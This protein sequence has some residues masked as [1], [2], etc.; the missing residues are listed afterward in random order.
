MLA[1]SDTGLGMDAATRARVF[2]PFFTTKEQG[3]GTGPRPRD[4][5]RHRE[6]ERR[7]HLGLQRAR[8]RHDVQGLP[9]AV[10]ADDRRAG[11][12]ASDAAETRRARG[13]RRCC[14]SRTRT[15]SARSRARCCAGSGYVVLEA[16][17]G[18]R[19]ARASPSGTPAP[20]HL[21]VTDVVMPHMSGRELAERLV[22][23][24]GRTMKVLFMSGYTD[25]AVMHRELM[26]GSAFLQKPFTPDAF[27]R[28]VRGV[29]DTRRG[30]Q[31]NLRLRQRHCSCTSSAVPHVRL[32]GSA[33]PAVPTSERPCTSQ[34]VRRRRAISAAIRRTFA[35][36]RPASQR[37]G[38]RR[39][40][41]RR[42]SRCARED[43]GYFSG[44]SPHRAG[45]SVSVSAGRRRAAVSR[46]GVAI[47]ARWSARP[48]GDRRLRPLPLDR[49]G[50]GAARAMQ[51]QVIYEMHVGTFTREGTWAAARARAAELAALGITLI[52]VM[53][54]A[55][56]PGRFG[57]GYDGVDLFA[58]D[59]SLRHA[60][61]I[62]AR[63]V[64]AAHALGLGVILDVVYNHFGPDGNYLRA[65]SPDYFTDRYEN[66]WGEAI[67]F[68]GADAARC[69]S[70][71][72][73]T[74][75]TG[76]TSSTSTACA[77]TR[78]SRSSTP[79][80]RTS[81]PRSAARAREAARRAHDLLVAENE[82]QD[83]RLVRP[84]DDGGYGLDA[85][86]NDDFH[87][88][89]DGRRSPAATRRTTP[90]TAARRRSSSRRRSTAFCIRGS[91]TRGRSSAA[92]RRRSDL[93]PR[94]A[95]S[96]HR[97]T[98]I[99]SRTRRAGCARIS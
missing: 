17:H 40:A 20:I 23:R 92:A 95:S 70:S 94:S 83:T 90:T 9:A 46:S 28:K 42:D 53:P 58:P 86:W 77:S 88:T 98:T 5:L 75:R 69:A 84:V 30:A 76:S 99:R 65:F 39:A 47:S 61:T 8:Q 37:R 15:P 60:R 11:D 34:A 6:A 25:H 96:V 66:E 36:G 68:D 21:M 56:F 18:A 71:S 80:R 64:D 35:S 73:R 48:L 41:T 49:R 89:R 67:N 27:A 79:R 12:A 50:V 4:R 38:R 33:R 31:L 81:S 93:A 45:R 59:A 78:R 91:A 24:R 10:D 26:P 2:E 82:P 74:P 85:L 63:F 87:H 32:I 54:V 72:S 22:A 52:E 16:R 13:W 1:V 43:N 44:R 19:R 3:K 14:S 57:W 62:S 97:R 7:L 29:L 55:E 51:G